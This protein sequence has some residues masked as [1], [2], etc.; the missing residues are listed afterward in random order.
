[1]KWN[2]P[3]SPPPPLRLLGAMRIIGNFLRLHLVPRFKSPM[4]EDTFKNP[5]VSQASWLTHFPALR[6]QRQ[7][8][9]LQ[10]WGHPGLHS[11]FQ[12]YIVRT[13]LPHPHSP[14]K[15]VKKRLPQVQ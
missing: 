1:M 7:E 8:D 3:P 2:K 9:L 6:R 10:L 11:K 13:C 4:T 5:H 12:G 14:T 15:K